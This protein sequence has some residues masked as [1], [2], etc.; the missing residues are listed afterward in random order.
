MSG[1]DERTC[2]GENDDILCAKWFCT[3]FEHRP[4][5]VMS[6]IEVSID[7][8]KHKHVAGAQKRERRKC[9]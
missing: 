7:E 5:H 6:H 1:S 8:K 9:G 4:R 2:D 3:V